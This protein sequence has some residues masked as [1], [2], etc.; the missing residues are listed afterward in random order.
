MIAPLS[1][2]L[3]TPRFMQLAQVTTLQ[4]IVTDSIRKIHPLWTPRTSR[5]MASFTTPKS[6][7]ELVAAIEGKSR[8]TKTELN[9]HTVERL[10]QIWN[11]IKPVKQAPVLP[12]GWKKM[13][14]K[15]LKTLY[16]ENCVEYYGRAQDGHWSRWKRPTLVTELEMWVA[17]RQEEAKLLGEDKAGD[18]APFCQTCGIPFIIRTN[19]ATHQD[20]W[21]CIRFPLCRNT[22][23]LSMNGID[24]RHLLVDQKSQHKMEG[25]EDNRP[26][27]KP[28][29]AAPGREEAQSSSWEMCLEQED[30][31]VM[32]N[33]N[34]TQLEAQMIADL[35]KKGQEEKIEDHVE[36]KD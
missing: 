29:L 35:R 30:P 36:K 16:L 33:A 31:N 23:P 26:K 2:A 25:Y 32:I 18:P 17:D 15:S 4:V 13:D 24:T 7:A 14:V 9:Q 3:C 19:R 20:F 10:K 27:R 28:P 11:M 1:V 6:K 12:V 34:L 22:L 5:L 8:L 21:G